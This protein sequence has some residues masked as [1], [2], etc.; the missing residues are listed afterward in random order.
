MRAMTTKLSNVSE[1]HQ[2]QRINL[3]D[4][5][6]DE[7]CTGIKRNS[8]KVRYLQKL[9]LRVATKPN[10]RPLVARAQYEALMGVAH[11]AAFRSASFKK[12]PSWSKSS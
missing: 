11:M 5:E 8:C 10:G 4:E 12:E 3:T 7:I 6:I 1:L 2:H 9:G